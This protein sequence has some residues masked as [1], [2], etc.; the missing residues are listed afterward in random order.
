MDHATNFRRFRSFRS[1][2]FAARRRAGTF[3]PLGWGA[4]TKRYFVVGGEY[5]DTEFLDF[6]EGHSEERFGP[7]DERAAHE[8][9]RAVTG[10]T[11]DNALIRYFIRRDDE[12]IGDRWYVTGGEYADTGFVHMAPGH[13]LD[14]FGPYDRTGAMT[15]WRELAARTVD[16]AMIR[17]DL[18]SEEEL[19]ERRREA[20][21]RQAQH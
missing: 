6:A 12:V 5:A 16:S 3:F 8:C 19:E 11:V 18:C 21:Q 20:Q 2:I 1:E 17:Y 15:K 13:Q 14:V 7:F 10:K 9:W 4:M